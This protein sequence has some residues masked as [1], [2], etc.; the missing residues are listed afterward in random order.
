MYAG[1]RAQSSAGG[2]YD[3]AQLPRHETP[4]NPEA[5]TALEVIE[6]ANGETIWYDRILFVQ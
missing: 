5:G 2:E 3:A 4:V 1:D 6:L